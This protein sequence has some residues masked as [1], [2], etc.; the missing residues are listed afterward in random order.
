MLRKMGSDRTGSEVVG[1][2]WRKG[3]WSVGA[4]APVW[5]LGHGGI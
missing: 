2:V 4:G 5:D 1:D 3:H